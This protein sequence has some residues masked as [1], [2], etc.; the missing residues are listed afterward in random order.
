MSPKSRRKGNKYN[1]Q[2]RVQSPAIA[3]SATSGTGTEAGSPV[4]VTARPRP[5]AARASATANS[6]A[7]YSNVPRELKTIG[8]LAGALLII[9]I[10]VA[11]VIL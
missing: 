2:R 3:R 6:V 4:S 11:V 8:I 10:V 7:S 1:K 5:T 9:L